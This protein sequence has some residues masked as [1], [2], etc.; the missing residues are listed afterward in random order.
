MSVPDCKDADVCLSG[1]YATASTGSST[2][3]RLVA[4]YTLIN[5]PED[6]E[7]DLMCVHVCVCVCTR[8]RMCDY[9]SVK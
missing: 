1:S 5:I 3:N 2:A 8:T 7:G 4:A 9:Q 6:V